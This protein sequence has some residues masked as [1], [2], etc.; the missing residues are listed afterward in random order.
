MEQGKAL[1]TPPE[2][3]PRTKNKDGKPLNIWAAR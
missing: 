2:G 1:L 3:T